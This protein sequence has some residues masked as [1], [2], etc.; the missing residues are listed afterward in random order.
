V[1]SALEQYYLTYRSY[2]N[3]ISDLADVGLVSESRL[4]SVERKGY[5]YAP[6][7]GGYQFAPSDDAAPETVSDAAPRPISIRP[8]RS[9]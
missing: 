5:S 6:T 1:E 7:S 8:I 3:R 2:P 4:E 9:E